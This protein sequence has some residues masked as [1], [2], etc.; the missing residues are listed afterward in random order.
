[1]PTY[2]GYVLSFIGGMLFALLVMYLGYTAGSR[3]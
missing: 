3:R 1:M 2:F